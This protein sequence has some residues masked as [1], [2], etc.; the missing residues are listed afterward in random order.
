MGFDFV[1]ADVFS[2]RPFGGNQLAVFPDATGI[3]NETMFVERNLQLGTIAE[4]L[5]RNP[6]ARRTDSMPR[7]V[8]SRIN[9]P[10]AETFELLLNVSDAL[11]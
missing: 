3:A 8:G 2:D 7:I 9:I 6:L 1:L 5:S 10:R 11:R 4:E